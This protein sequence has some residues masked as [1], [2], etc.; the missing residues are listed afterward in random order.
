MI[1][2]SLPVSCLLSLL[3]DLVQAHCP[4][5][6]F[7][8]FRVYQGQGFSSDGALSKTFFYVLHL[9]QILSEK[10]PQLWQLWPEKWHPLHCENC[11]LWENAVTKLPECSRIKNT[12]LYFYHISLLKEEI[13]FYISVIENISFYISASFYD[14]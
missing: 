1:L 6:K 10:W 4:E 14:F 5:K 3:C 9:G 13:E 12:G 8:Y 11:P 7:V 2:V